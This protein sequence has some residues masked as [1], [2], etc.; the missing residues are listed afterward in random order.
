MREPAVPKHNESVW[1]PPVWQ[2]E[3]DEFSM[4]PPMQ[5]LLESAP[6]S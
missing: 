1:G 2:E 3:I 6:D 5:R 4:A